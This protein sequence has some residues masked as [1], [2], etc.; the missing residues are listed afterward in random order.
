MNYNINYTLIFELDEVK[1]VKDLEML[2]IGSIYLLVWSVLF[3][4]QLVFV[5][6]LMT[7]SIKTVA[8]FSLFNFSFFFLVPLLPFRCLWHSI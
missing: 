3:L 7:E 2:R 1:R 5:K 4:S 8:I 6:F